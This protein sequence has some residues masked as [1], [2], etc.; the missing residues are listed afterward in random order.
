MSVCVSQALV[1]V[2]TSLELKL[3]PWGI[4]PP[5]RLSFAKNTEPYQQ[6]TSADARRKRKKRRRRR[7][8]VNERII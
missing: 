4:N 1:L 3:K 5:L 2:R 6:P 8:R 7:S